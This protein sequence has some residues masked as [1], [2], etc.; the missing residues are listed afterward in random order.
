[1][2][3]TINATQALLASKI[4]STPKGAEKQKTS[5]PQHEEA[6][7]S[8]YSTAMRSMGMAG[9]N[10]N[11]GVNSIKESTETPAKEI[12]YVDGINCDV[13]EETTGDAANQWWL[14]EMNY[15]N[16]PYLPKSKVQHI[17]L[18][19]DTKFCRVYDGD[20]SGMYGGWVMKQSDVEGLTPEEI[21]D[22]FA[23]PATPVKICDVTIPAG[24]KMRT[25]LCN[26]LKGWGSGG[27]VQFDLMGQRVGNFDNER[28]IQ[29]G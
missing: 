7:S 6:Y 27:G 22:K 4:A 16:P 24:T 15:D 11:Q 17:E 28:D 14:E 25:G 12:N 13:I 10:F 21:Q 1:M 8:T 18:N 5:N 23:L 3:V 19:E 29:T 9:I 26:P 20:V 2:N